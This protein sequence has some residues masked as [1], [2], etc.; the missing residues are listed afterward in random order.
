MRGDNAP[1]LPQVACDLPVLPIT[2]KRDWT[3]LEHINLAD[4]HY[5]KPCRVDHLLGAEM[6][7]KVLRHGWRSSP[8]NSRTALETEL[9]DGNDI[10][11]LQESERRRSKIW[12][13]T[14]CHHYAGDL[15]C[16]KFLHSG[17]V[18]IDAEIELIVLT[19]TRALAVPSTVTWHVISSTLEVME[20]W[21]TVVT[22]AVESSCEWVGVTTHFFPPH[23]IRCGE[24]FD[25]TFSDLGTNASSQ[26]D[27]TGNSG[28]NCL[29]S[30]S[31]TCQH[32]T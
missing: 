28:N 4:P 25:N 11:V 12:W 26:S 21:F 32:V 3:H 20:A 27:L 2:P 1:I 8:Q 15:Q 9:Y 10:E 5:D 30:G 7:V 19:R 14:A 31:P 22:G 29:T 18:G 24:D 6:F 16:G 13:Q 23:V 17:C